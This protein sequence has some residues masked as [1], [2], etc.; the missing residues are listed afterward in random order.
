MEEV[1]AVGEWLYDGSV[2]TPVRVVR[3]DYDF[4]F[5]I[6]EADGDPQ[7]DE[8]PRLNSDGHAFYV[9]CKPGWVGGEPFW[10]DSIG[11]MTVDEA[12]REAESKV[13]GA[14]RWS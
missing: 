3:L 12:Q 8:R 11:Y 6:G 4:W 2:P 9:R 7:P 1:V 5:A 10:P 13:P 14:V